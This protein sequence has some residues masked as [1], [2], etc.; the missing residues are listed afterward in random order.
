MKAKAKATKNQKEIIEKKLIPWLNIRREK[1]PP[2]GWVS[3]IRGA[4]GINARQ[5]ADLL[6][7]DSSVVIRMEA[8]EKQKKISL[9]LLEKAATAMNCKLIYALV[10]NDNYES[11]DVILDQRAMGV[12]KQLVQKVEHSMLLESQGRSED[13]LQKRIREIANEL[14]NEMDRRLWDSDKI[15]KANV[16]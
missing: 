3:A 7:V 11:L 5:L 12:A 13:Q 6:N 9:E 2:S 4:L 8:R 15:L 14:K 10:P 16:K 1:T